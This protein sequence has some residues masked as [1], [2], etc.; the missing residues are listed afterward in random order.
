MTMQIEV[1]GKPQEILDGTT[2]RALLEAR[3]INPNVVAC[4]LNLTILKR[5]TLAET[6]LHDGDKLEIIQM[7]GGG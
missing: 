3:G 6:P 4:E 5:A 2:V 7:I 1:N